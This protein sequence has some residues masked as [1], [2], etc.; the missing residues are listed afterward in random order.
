MD[1]AQNLTLLAKS[2]MPTIAA[3]QIEKALKSK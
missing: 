1:M 2:S 3:N